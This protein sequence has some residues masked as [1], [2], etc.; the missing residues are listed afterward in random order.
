MKIDLIDFGREAAIPVD[1]IAGWSDK[2][3]FSD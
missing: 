3:E 2:V 1:L